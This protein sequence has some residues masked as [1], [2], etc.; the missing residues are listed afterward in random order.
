MILKTYRILALVL[1]ALGRSFGFL[2][3]L[4]LCSSTLATL[5]AIL[6]ALSFLGRLHGLNLLSD[7]LSRC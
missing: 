7:C 3:F 6:R 1:S 5:L 4:V 2:L